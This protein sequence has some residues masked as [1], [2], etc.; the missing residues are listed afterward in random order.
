M[1]HPPLRAPTRPIGM[2]IFRSEEIGATSYSVAFPGGLSESA[3]VFWSPTNVLEGGSLSLRAGDSLK[4]GGWIA[5]GAGQSTIAISSSTLPGI[6]EGSPTSSTDAKSGTRSLRFPGTGHHAIRVPDAGAF[7]ATRKLTLSL[8]I[9]PDQA[10]LGS[11]ARGIVSKRIA[12]GNQDAFTLYTSYS[13]K[14]A[15]KLDSGKEDPL[16]YVT[17]ASLNTAWQFISVVFDGDLPTAE[18]VKIFIDGNLS[19]TGS[20]P[21]GYI[22][23]RASDLFIGTMNSNYV[24]EGAPTCFAG[25]IDDVRIDR[26]S[27]EIRST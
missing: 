2:A 6:K 24:S 10:S 7:D 5:G 13:G 23:D 26:D 8:W 19:A 27:P 25:L 4:L 22:R 15:L 21:T 18:R 14:L 1:A 3:D 11:K 17:T 12:A 16:M 20:H 9:K